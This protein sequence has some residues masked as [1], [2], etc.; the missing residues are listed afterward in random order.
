MTKPE[1]QK[2][3]ESFV[4]KTAVFPLVY[5]ALRGKN[6]KDVVLLQCYTTLFRCLKENEELRRVAFDMFVMDEVAEIGLCCSEKT[7]IVV[8]CLWIFDLLTSQVVKR[9]A[10]D[11]SDLDF[12]V[13][14]LN[15]NALCR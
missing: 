15:A 9:T 7:A 2:S 1:R 11:T 10:V 8:Y 13:R 4:Q 6:V 12:S 3:S 5:R 14:G